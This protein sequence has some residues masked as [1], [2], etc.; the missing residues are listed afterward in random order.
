MILT[1]SNNEVLADDL[2]I[3][4]DEYA[5]V[6]DMAIEQYNL[7][8]DTTVWPLLYMYNLETESESSF[9]EWRGGR[10]THH[11]RTLGAGV[12][13]RNDITLD[14]DLETRITDELENIAK[15]V[16][17]YAD[18]MVAEMEAELEVCNES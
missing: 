18:E 9:R 7:M 14:D 16:L 4:G 6:R 8:F 5:A 10:V 15:V 3:L 17:E 13:I 1:C 12:A 2:G 11:Y